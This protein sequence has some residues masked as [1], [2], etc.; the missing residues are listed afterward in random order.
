[1]KAKAKK[2]AKKSVKLHKQK[3]I[4]KVVIKKQNHAAK[5]KEDLSKKNKKENKLGLLKEANPPKSKENK[6]VPSEKLG[7]AKS[8]KSSKEPG[9]KEKRRSQRDL[10]EV[11]QL[12]HLGKERG[13]LTFEEVNDVLPA[14]ISSGDEIDD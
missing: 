2:K 11:K 8:Q 12:I 5:A 13:Y 9:K 7:A 4:K 6:P 14:D 3:Q 1:M 10:K